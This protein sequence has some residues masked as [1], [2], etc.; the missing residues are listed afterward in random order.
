MGQPGFCHRPGGPHPVA[1]RQ[2]SPVG[3]PS[4]G[5]AV[6]VLIS[7]TTADTLGLQVGEHYTLFLTGQTTQIPVRIAG[8]WQA[9][10]PAD[11]FWFYQPGAFD[12][13]L[14][15]S[16][17]AFA[18]Q[19]AGVVDAPVATAIWYQIFDGSRVRPANV[20]ELLENVAV[21]EARVTALLNDTTLDASPVPALQSYGKSANLLTL[22]LTIFSLPV[23]GLVVYFISLIA[24][25]VVRRGQSEIAIMRSRGISSQKIVNLYLLEG[26]LVGGLGLAGGLL[27]G[28]AAARLMSR[29]RTFLD[30]GFLAGSGSE[31]LA[32]VFTPTALVYALVGVASDAGGAPGARLFSRRGTRSSPCAGS[33]PGRCWRPCGSATIWTCSCWCCP[34]TAG[35]N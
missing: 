20:N 35:T 17:E 24:G 10:N 32:I 15:T 26:L 6:E 5:E 25:M 9:N 16:E 30:T 27:L 2:L 1:G 4:L 19:V 3:C 11:P 21:V 7:R 33:R 14:L 12:E 18:T 23:I 28:Q 13:I 29:M 34:C 31:P 8:V 22:E